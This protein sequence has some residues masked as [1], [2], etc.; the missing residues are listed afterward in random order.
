MRIIRIMDYKY[1]FYCD[2]CKTI[3]TEKIYVGSAQM[4]S[5]PECGASKDINQMRKNFHKIKIK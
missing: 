1:T 3:F 2:L 4:I 5:C